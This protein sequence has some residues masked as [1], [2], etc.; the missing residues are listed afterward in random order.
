M[1][2][3]TT[4]A[5]LQRAVKFN[6]PTSA[7]PCIAGRPPPWARESSSLSSAH[8]SLAQW[9]SLSRGANAAVYTIRYVDST[10]VH[11]PSR[12]PDVF[13]PSIP[14]ADDPDSRRESVRKDEA[15]RAE[16]LQD[17]RELPDAP[18]LPPGG[19]QAMILDILFSYCRLNP[20]VGGYH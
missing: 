1:R 16:I 17:V 4:I 20:H 10:E 15:I 9:P 3:G 19:R 13:S 18:F 12:A 2:H 14:L 11:P 7:P 8:A 5:D 6:G